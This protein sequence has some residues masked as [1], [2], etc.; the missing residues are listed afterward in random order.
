[1]MPQEVGMNSWEGNKM[2][3]KRK[4]QSIP[5]RE[6]AGARRGI[7]PGGARQEGREKGDG[8]RVSGKKQLQ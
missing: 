5:A 2:N 3:V 4:S 6:S 1:V 8:K 7:V